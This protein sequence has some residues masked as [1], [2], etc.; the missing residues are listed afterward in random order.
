M[1][2]RTQVWLVNY[3]KYIPGHVGLAIGKKG[4]TFFAH[5]LFKDSKTKK[6]SYRAVMPIDI[7][8]TKKKKYWIGYLKPC[9]EHL[10][11]AKPFD[12]ILDLIRGN[13]NF[14]TNSCH[15]FTQHAIDRFVENPRPWFTTTQRFTAGSL[16][17]LGLGA[18]FV[19]GFTW[20]D[21]PSHFGILITLTSFILFCLVVFI[22]LSLLYLLTD[23]PMNTTQVNCAYSLPMLYSLL[24]I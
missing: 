16:L 12:E 9:K 19:L 14:I 23:S 24:T 6:I 2:T 13:Y 15:L 1:S 7:N 11:I 18:S 3:T 4:G 17:L 20:K 22:S 10:D 5:H 21:T 8:S